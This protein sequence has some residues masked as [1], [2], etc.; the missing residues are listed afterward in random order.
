MRVVLAAPAPAE[1][2]SKN[3]SSS[4]DNNTVAPVEM[5]DV[6][7]Q[8]T[9]I[10]DPLAEEILKGTLT[11]GDTI[12]VTADKDKLQFSQKAK[13]EGAGTTGAVAT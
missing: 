7:V 11:E 1:P 5:P 2:A 10:E 3:A 4:D 13:A 6:L 9:L 12:M 8:P